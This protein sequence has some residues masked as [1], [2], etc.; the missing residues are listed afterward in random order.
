MS[1]ASLAPAA[2]P[3]RPAAQWLPAVVAA[4][5][6]PGI[7]AY[8][9]RLWWL[10]HYQFFPLALVGACML[11][12]RSSHGPAGD[13]R[14]GVW[15]GWI[16]AGLLSLAA[17]NAFNSPW[18]TM[19]SALLVVSAWLYGRGGTSAI[20][21]QIPALVMVLTT[22][23]PPLNLDHTLVTK[24]QAATTRISSATLD[25]LGVTHVTQGN[26]IEIPGQSLFVEEACSGINSLFSILACTLFYLLWTRRHGFVWF[27]LLL[28]APLWVLAANACRVVLT[29]VL[30]SR[31]EIA[32]DTGWLHDFLG[33][34][35]FALAVLLLFAT[36]RLLTFYSAVLLRRRSSPPATPSG[37]SVP[38]R[39]APDV[40]RATRWRVPAGVALL[41][42]LGQVPTIARQ[43][44]DFSAAIRGLTPAELGLEFLPQK[45]GYWSRQGFERIDRARRSDSGEHSQVWKYAGSAERVIVSLDYP[46]LGWHELSECYA[47]QGWHL[48]MRE[49]RE[50]TAD[51]PPY[52]ELTLSNPATG[53]YG[54]VWFALFAREGRFLSPTSTDPLEDLQTRFATQLRGL[55]LWGGGEERD[56][57]SYQTQLFLETYGPPSANAVTAGRTLFLTTLDKLTRDSAAL[58]VP[59]SH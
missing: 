40:M 22:L 30:Q 10:P 44:R 59:D 14:D 17:A 1:H 15:V 13:V 37:T 50:A 43:G 24:L 21:W 32:A 29:V 47:V 57:P 20:L 41:L 36:E 45:Q 7:F 39:A 9:A 55:S 46:F 11:A 49:A 54:K 42:L 58:L 5:L 51:Q 4:A 56:L 35:A 34:A 2:T 12:R 25:V 48:E 31:W 33:F 6:L 38:A 26:V 28:S 53:R 52:V 18:L 16:T 27:F 23:R 3:A 19:I 8:Y